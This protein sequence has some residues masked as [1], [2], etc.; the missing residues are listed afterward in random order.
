MV[1]SRSLYK[2]FLF[3]LFSSLKWG[4]DRLALMSLGFVNFGNLEIAR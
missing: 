1:P 4:S 3:S 2:Q